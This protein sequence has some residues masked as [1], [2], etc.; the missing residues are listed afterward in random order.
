[1]DELLLHCC[2]APC[3]AGCLTSLRAEG[4]QPR[5]FLYNPNIHPF[6]EYKSRRESLS[7]FAANE[8]LEYDT[9]GDYGLVHFLKTISPC[10]DEKPE[11]CER[12]YRMRL[13]R[14]ASF[15]AQKGYPSFSTT[16]LI[17]PYQDHEKIRRIGEEEGKKYGVEFL[18]RDFRPFFREGQAR[19]RAGNF[20]MQKY[21]G[22]IFSEKERYSD[23]L[24]QKRKDE[25]N[26]NTEQQLRTCM[27][28]RD[29]FSRLIL[30]TGE[31]GLEKLSH[32]S[33]LIFGLG[34]VGSWAAEALVRSGIGKI[35]IIDHDTVCSSNINRQIEATSLTIGIPK[36]EVLKKRLLE[37]N[38]D[39]KI[40]AYDKLFCRENA[41]TF[42]IEEADYVIDAI[43]TVTHKLDLLET[44]CDSK[45]VLFSSMGMAFKMDPSRIKTAS[46]WKT[47]VCPLARVVRQGLKKRGFKGDFT[48]VYSDEEPVKKRES[49]SPDKKPVNGSI[50]T[51][52]A[53]AG[54]LL[55]S[56]VLQDVFGKEN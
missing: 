23:K 48:V 42:G 22:C 46:I 25:A 7:L 5:L 56:L 13:Q 1:M 33:V 8:K 18:Y 29:M 50:V 36:A 40:T 53:S 45:A 19:A 55:A 15:A 43:D 44:V 20:Y 11:R 10:M 26:K 17:S 31:E 49:V 37:I 39:C 30:L 27:S 47:N 52:T 3:L 14:T 32:K 51:V 28:L 35:G 54:F 9:D 24:T 2:C 38:P 34:G 21:C 41:K 12:C 16:L 6:T 4:I